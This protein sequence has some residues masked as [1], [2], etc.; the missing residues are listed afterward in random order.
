MLQKIKGILKYSIV[1]LITFFLLWKVWMSIEPQ[2]NQ[3]RADF[4]VEV[5]NSSNLFL[6]I[7]SG[8]MAIASHVVRSV[9]WNLLLSP[10]NHRIK[11]WDAFFSVMIGYFVNLAIPRGGELSRCYNI[12]KSDGVPLDVSI[13]T[14]ISERIIDLFFL[15]LLIS[16]S[17]LIELDTLL[18]FFNE[19][20]AGNG[21][22]LKAIPFWQVIAIIGVVFG[23]LLLLPLAM[24]KIK[25][26]FALRLFLKIKKFLVGLKKGLLV[27]FNLEH[28]LLFIFYSLLIW[29]FY[30][31]MMY[32]VLLAFPYTE[33]LSLMAGLSI[34]VISGIAMAL[35]LPGGAGS[36]HTLVPAGLIL[37]YGVEADQAKAFAIILHGWHFL[38]LIIFG[39]ISMKISQYRRK[40]LH[41][42]NQR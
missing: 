16:C 41:H 30:Y 36:Y 9:R 6:L 37:L 5:W 17:F 32:F 7:L 39:V 34:F 8:I 19:Q 13:G 40:H 23:L 12:Y 24:L 15:L 26:N 35:P 11:F 20:L 31:F 38:I 28:N 27:V 3:T 25:K 10:L 22:L 29:V 33:H 2:E 14:V 42:A 18:G 1:L 21:N 4:I